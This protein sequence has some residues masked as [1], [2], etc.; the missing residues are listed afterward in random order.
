MFEDPDEAI[1]RIEADVLRAQH[2]PE[3][4]SALRAATEAVRGSAVSR[5]R[6]IA[7][8]VDS[9]GQVVGLQ[10]TNA[11]CARGGAAVTADVL[12]L[13]AAARKQAQQR[14]V[15]AAAAV[16]GED[17]PVV[18]TLRAAAGGDQGTATEWMPGGGR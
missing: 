12:S 1:A 11:A 5:Q 2:R 3:R 8:D 7:V 18:G 9:T 10:I 16:L 17:D 13:I 4:L 15:G 6:D 14:M